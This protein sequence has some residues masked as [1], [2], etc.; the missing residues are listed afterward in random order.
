MIGKDQTVTARADTYSKDLDGVFAE[1]SGTIAQVG[2]DQWTAIAPED[3]RQ[4]NVVLDHIV[5]TQL[6]MPQLISGLANDGTLPPVTGEDIEHGNQHHMSEAAQVARA[7]VLAKL[8]QA[9]A[10]YRALLPTL[11]DDQLDRAA[12]FG[13]FGG[14]VTPEVLIQVIMIC[15]AQDHLG[16]VKSAIAG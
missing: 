7:D 5:N 14:D 10:A 13:P 6:L 3:G 12:F 16:S 11:T 1:I 15:H 4:I 8:D 9:Q 2:D